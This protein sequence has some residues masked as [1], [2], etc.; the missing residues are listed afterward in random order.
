MVKKENTIAKRKTRKPTVAEGSRAKFP[1]HSVV[2]ALRIPKAIIEQGAGKACT[3][4]Q[5]AAFLGVGSAGAFSVEIGSAVK[6]GFLERPQTGQIQPTALVKKILKPQSPNDVIDGFREAIL[7]AP[8]ISTV[9]K[10]YRGENLPD[11][12]YFW[13]TTSDGREAL[14]Q[15]SES[16]DLSGI[17]FRAKPL[18]MVPPK[19]ISRIRKFN[20]WMLINKIED[21]FHG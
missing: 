2:K 10:H 4:T 20:K 13:V 1:R 14:A 5:A 3:P 6:Y 8:D 9:Y 19:D 11:D 15:V 17:Q 21:Y 16:I 7:N 12:V 18:A